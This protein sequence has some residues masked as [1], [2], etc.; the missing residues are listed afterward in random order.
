MLNTAQG[1]AGEGP[2]F[3]YGWRADGSFGLE[4]ERQVELLGSLPKFSASLG[5][6]LAKGGEHVVYFSEER[7]TILKIALPGIFGYV[8]DEEMLMDDRTLQVRP[9]LKHRPSLPSEYLFRWAVLDQIFGLVTTFA[10]VKLDDKNQPSLVIQQ[11]FIGSEEDDLPEWDEIAELLSAH[12]FSRI[13]DVHIADPQIKGAIWYRKK[14]GVLLSDV[15][16]RNFRRT[17]GGV[18]FPI[19]IVVNIVPPGASKI[20]PAASEPF[21]LQNP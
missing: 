9:K 8:V 16:P 10:G 2:P 13:D 12:D 20:L 21:A 17:E 7:S 11:P 18:I 4:R 15:F 5:E 14:D 3:R 1:L 6:A 19:D